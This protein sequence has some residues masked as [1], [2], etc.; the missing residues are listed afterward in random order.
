MAP[1]CR[2]LASSALATL[3]ALFVSL[4]AAAQALPRTVADVFAALERPPEPPDAAAARAVLAKPAPATGDKPDLVEAHAAR[5]RAAAA[6]SSGRSCS[7]S[8]RRR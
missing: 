2:F 4:P 1:V 5:A 7:T 3:L 6:S 8:S